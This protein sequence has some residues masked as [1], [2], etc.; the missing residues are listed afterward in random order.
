MTA[1]LG[2]VSPDNTRGSRDY[3]LLQFLYN[4]GGRV[5][6]VADTR[7]G[8]LTLDAPRRS[9]CSEKAGNA[10]VSPVGEHRRTCAAPVAERGRAPG[11]T[12][13]FVNRYGRS[14]SRSGIADISVVMPSKQQRLS[15]PARPWGHPAYVAPYDGD[16]PI[17][18][19]C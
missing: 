6:E 19:W 5:Q 13:L 16:A 8:W 12:D 3:S 14:L 15:E 7:L 2:A 11:T 18:V 4:T 17:T 10:N 1:L 9:N